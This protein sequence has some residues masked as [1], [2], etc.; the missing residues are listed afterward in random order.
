MGIFTGLHYNTE[1][2]T[3]VPESVIN[4]L[5]YMLGETEN[6]P[7]LPNHE[8]FGNTEWRFMLQ[9]NSNCP[10]AGTHSTLRYNNISESYCLCIRCNLK[11]CND[12]IALFCNWIRPYIDKIEVVFN[13]IDMNDQELQNLYT[14]I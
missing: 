14:P 4:V 11:N 8:L 2:K 13:Y 9:G 7:V 1:L 5:R 12:E 3:W 10:D 6:E